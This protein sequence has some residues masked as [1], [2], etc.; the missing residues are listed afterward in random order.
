M[1]RANW[2][3]E[4]AGRYRSA[5]GRT[6]LV[7]GPRPTLHYSTP[8]AGTVW[9]LHHGDVVAPR[10]YASTLADAKALAAQLRDGW[11]ALDAERN[12]K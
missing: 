1:A 2:I 9:A 4:A 8:V 11:D 5:D 7:R 3:I 10:A 12:S 6:A